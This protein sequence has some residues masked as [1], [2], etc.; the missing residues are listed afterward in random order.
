[1]NKN[2]HNIAI[3]QYNMLPYEPK[4]FSNSIKCFSSKMEAWIINNQTNIQKS[5]MY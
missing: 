3:E 2:Y 5:F 1:M 4:R